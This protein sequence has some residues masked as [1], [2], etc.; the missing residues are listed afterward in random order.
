MR[1]YG[2]VERSNGWINDVRKLEVVA[3]GK[4]P[5]RPKLTWDDVLKKDREL[6]GMVTVDPENRSEWRGRLRRR[7]LAPPSVQED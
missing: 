1:W 4:R 5:G 3:E 6:L 2:H 7:R